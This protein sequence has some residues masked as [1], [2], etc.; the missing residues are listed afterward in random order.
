[1]SNTTNYVKSPRDRTDA[2]L[3]RQWSA[4][5]GL[6]AVGRMRVGARDRK[7][8]MSAAPADARGSGMLYDAIA[9]LSGHLRGGSPEDACS[10]IGSARQTLGD[11][12]VQR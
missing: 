9:G 3:L 2:S 11:D 4:G 7:K 8:T 1:M 5:I 12:G 10:G 6:I